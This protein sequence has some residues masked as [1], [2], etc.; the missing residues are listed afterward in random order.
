M[1]SLVLWFG[2]G[3]AWFLV[4]GPV[5]QAAGELA[6]EEETRSRLSG[7]YDTVGEPAPVSRWWWLLPPVRLVLSL[8]RRGALRDRVVG[9]LGPEDLQAMTR[10]V[11]LARGWMYVAGGAWLIAL[12]ETWE[13]VEHH[14]WPAAA[15]WAAVVLMSLVALSFGAVALRRRA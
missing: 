4:I 7:I 6:S 13:L 3:G 8:R 5:F 11:D 2:F 15:Y 9:A 1:H 10:Y 14:E 12:K